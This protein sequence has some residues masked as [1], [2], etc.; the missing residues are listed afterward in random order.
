MKTKKLLRN[1]L[2][3]ISLTLAVLI[4]LFAIK[5]KDK[6]LRPTSIKITKTGIDVSI[7]SLH[8]IEE[9]GGKR[10]WELNA[11]KAEVINS[12]GITLLKDI[13]MVFFQKNRENLSLSADTGIIQN[14]TKNIELS[15]NIKVSS[16]QG[17]RLNTNNLKWTSEHRIIQTDD[18]IKISGKNLTITGKGMTI[19]ID[20]EIVE[21]WSGVKAI[22]Y[23]DKNAL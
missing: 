21:I 1:I 18:E 20:A 8:L 9:E 7:D 3:F 22:Y 4:I 10:Q 13:Q 19:N 14:D 16:K 12:K 11:S 5:N 6:F 2:V 15:G 17:Y 23:D